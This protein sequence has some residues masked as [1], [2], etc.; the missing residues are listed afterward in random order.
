M[1]E[2]NLT[3]VFKRQ[4]AHQFVVARSTSKQR[5]AKLRRLHAAVLR[6]REAMKIALAADFRKS[7]HEV[8]I[9][10]TIC[11]NSEIRHMIRHLNRWMRPRRVGVRLPLLGSSA[12]IVQEPKGLCLIIGTW[13]FPFNL[14]LIPLAT[15]V[16]AGNCVVLKPSE[17][18]PHSAA[19]LKMIVAECFSEEEV[20]VVEGEAEL[21]QQLLALPFNHI[22]FTGST[23]IGKLVQAAAA[24]HLASVT[25]ELGGKSPVIVDESADL[26]RAASRIVWIKSLNGGQTCIAPD[27]VLVQE[28]VHDALVEKMQYWYQKYYGD[29]LEARRQTPDLCRVIHKRQFQM[30]QG[31]LQDAR[32]RGAQVTGSG[33]TDS[34]ERFVDLAI[35]TQVPDDADIWAHEIFGPLLPVRSYQQLDEVPA[36]INASG[37]PLA[38]YI[39]SKKEPNIRA[40]I[41][42]TR[43]GG[44]CINECALQ[45]FNPNLPFGG[46][47]G[48]GIG[49]Y[50]GKSGFQEFSNARSIARQHSPYPSTNIFLPPY[51]SRLMNLALD[52]ISKWL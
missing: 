1:T 17:H 29:T 43:G 18:A 13:N 10:E 40:I 35:L 9:S 21:A 41:R 24:Q 8:D 30:L 46:H 31:L 45:F 6:H 26:D 34:E 4:Q 33:F 25:L 16:A 3:T 12:R 5:K 44:V 47:N 50:H 7:P 52:W 32:A 37:K 11:I 28:S 15:A 27:Y 48:S 19:L 20:V 39:F 23:A 22:F 42:E 51:G 14:N 2:L 49:K 38:F 36:Y